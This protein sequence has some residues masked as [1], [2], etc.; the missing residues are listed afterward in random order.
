MQDPRH[1]RCASLRDTFGPFS[2]RWLE[3]CSSCNHGRLRQREGMRSMDNTSQV[4]RSTKAENTEK[5]PFIVPQ[6]TPGPRQPGS[7]P[8]LPVIDPPTQPKT[9]QKDPPGSPDVPPRTPEPGPPGQPSLPPVTDPP[10]QPTPPQ[11]DPP[12][13][14]DIPP[15]T[16]DPGPPGRPPL[17]PMTDPPTQPRTPITVRRGR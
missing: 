14:P 7:P 5:D 10:L 16:P 8:R 2:C 13:E 4:I 9:P 6:Q 17:P 1:H 12:I 15:Q 11:K 3:S